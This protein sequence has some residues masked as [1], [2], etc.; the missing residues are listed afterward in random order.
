MLIDPGLYVRYE[1]PAGRGFPPR[2]QWPRKDRPRLKRLNLGLGSERPRSQSP[3]NVL[4]HLPRRQTRVL[5]WPLATVFG[6][7]EDPRLPFFLKPMVTRRAAQNCGF[8]K[9]YRSKP[10]WA[11]HSAVLTVAQSI[12]AD[13]RDGEGN[14]VR[15][16]TCDK[17]HAGQRVLRTKYAQDRRARRE[18]RWRRGRTGNSRAAAFMTN[19]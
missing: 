12:R 11:T 3:S 8:D 6:F 2:W 15:G 17:I 19:D 7:I 1:H 4:A 9:P 10:D 5:T 14:R 18:G 13:I 16:C